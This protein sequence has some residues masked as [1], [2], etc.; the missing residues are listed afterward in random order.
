MKT[1]FFLWLLLIGMCFVS[2]LPH[3]PI[4]YYCFSE[5]TGTST[6]TDCSGNGYYGT[7][8]GTFVV[9]GTGDASGALMLEAA[10]Y[11]EALSFDYANFMSGITV[12][13]R[14][15]I[16]D[17]GGGTATAVSA[18]GLFSVVFMDGGI[19]C[20]LCSEP[21][22]VPN[23]GLH[24][25]ELATWH[26][27]AFVADIAGEKFYVYVDGVEIDSWDGV[28]LSSEDCSY[29]QF[30]FGGTGLG[31]T[32][33][34]FSDEYVI[35]NVPLSQNE[36]GEL[37]NDIDECSTGVHTCGISC[38]NTPGSFFCYCGDNYESCNDVD[39]CTLGTD[40]CDSSSTC[41][42]NIGSFTCACPADYYGDG[43][44]CQPCASD[45]S[46]APGSPTAADCVCNVGFEGDGAITCSDVDECSNSFHDCHVDAFC[47]NSFGSFECTCAEGTY[48]V[49]TSCVPCTEHATSPSGS[50]SAVECECMTGY[51]GDGHTAC[52]D[53]DECLMDVSDCDSHATCT[54]TP[55]SFTCDCDSDYFGDGVVCTACGENASSAPGS[56][57]G[58]ACEC[59]DGYE[60]DAVE[61]CQDIDECVSLSSDCAT[62]AVCTN[63][64]GSFS[65][66]C[67]ENYFGDGV[68][69][70][71]CA[72][73]ATSAAGS[74]TP[75]A[76]VCNVGFEGEGSVL[77]A[78]LDECVQGTHSC[79]THAQC[80][81]TLGS[82]TCACEASAH[83]YGDGT[84]CDPC[85][86]HAWYDAEDTE[87]C[88]CNE[89]YSGDGF[90]SCS[91]NDE[92]MFGTANCDNA[93]SCTNTAGSFTCSCDADYYGDGVSCTACAAFATSPAESTLPTAC[94]CDVG[95]QG[96]GWSSCED[97]DECESEASNCAS[98]D[99]G[100]ACTN[101]V[102]SFTC[103]CRSGFFGDGL[104]CEPCAANASSP[105]GSTLAQQCVCDE[106]FSGNAHIECTD[107]AV[108]DGSCDAHA[109]CLPG[110]TGST[111]FACSCAED[112]YGDGLTCT[113]CESDASAPSGSTNASSCVCN[114]GFV[115]IGSEGCSDLDECD[116]ATHNCAAAASGVCS[117]TAGSFECHCAAGYYGDGV[118]C[119]ACGENAWSVEA[120]DEAAGCVCAEGYEGVGAEGCTDA[121]ECTDGSNTCHPL[122]VC[123]N[124]GGSFTCTCAAGTYG[125]GKQ[126][127][128]CAAE[129]TSPEGSTSSKACVCNDGYS[130]AGA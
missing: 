41:F 40:D 102:S 54:N 100:G 60:G 3:Q 56:A 76:C 39:E 29:N 80:N 93:A 123:L 112:Y 32:V 127:D 22:F 129:A 11:G 90:V 109:Y 2:S 25:S 64:P 110:V 124:T 101:T 57:A 67:L 88:L 111:P 79:D 95:Y 125:N 75:N 87:E 24:E 12:A 113:A 9:D 82:F 105:E 8:S 26:H 84:W 86:T 27:F 119:V 69:C 85:A 115:G 70:T 53:Y 5:D 43:V 16:T 35:F 72:F 107:N 45:A 91:D 94:V 28:E 78:D 98:E 33:V 66:V 31:S 6:V 74:D 51:S 34:G 17:L 106:G 58:E 114:E 49:G 15:K 83:Y 30:F 36:V 96:D 44:A 117:N 47:T 103:A 126:C 108:C 20:N 59:V 1:L 19:V 50:L 99:E 4:V 97:V 7:M 52:Q 42:N 18:E 71:S 63:T 21:A 38:Q 55:G 116:L 128:T 10:A 65:C 13:F 61:G 46:A 118:L 62:T 37:V 92:C 73:G 120:T 121:D 48:G 130:G 89:G 122:A 23:N 68:N 14:A 81:N 77:C 104:A